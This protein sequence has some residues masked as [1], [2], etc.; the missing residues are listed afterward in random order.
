MKKTA[1]LAL[2]LSLA[3]LAA[4]GGGRDSAAGKP[5]SL[6]F[7]VGLDGDIYSLDPGLCWD[8][9]TNQVGAQ[10]AEGLVTLDEAGNL[11]PLLAKSWSQSDDLTY[12]YE[13]RDDVTFSD[14]SRMTMEDVLFTFNRSRDPEGGSFFSDFFADVESIEATGPWQ[15]TVRLGKPSAVFKFVPATAAGWI[16]SKDYYE[17]HP[18]DFGTE[19]GGMVGTGPFAYESWT[20]GQEIVL[21]KNTGYWNREKL[22]ANI[23]DRLVFKIIEDDTTRVLAMKNGEIDYCQVLPADM[24]GEIES[25]PDLALSHCDSYFLD[26]LALNTQKPPFDDRNARLAVAHAL[27]IPELFTAVIKDA[28]TPGSVLPFGPALYGADAGKWQEYIRAAEPSYNPDRARQY[29]SRSAYPNGF[30]FTLMV[31]TNSLYQQMGLY[32][33]E[34]LKQLNINAEIQRLPLEEISMHQ[35]GEYWDNDGRRIYDGLI[36]IWGADYPDLNGN[37]EF[38]YASSQAGENGVNAAVFDNPEVDG[39]ITEQRTTLDSEKRFDVQKRLVDIIAGEAPYII[40]NYELGHAALNKKYTNIRATSAGL[41]WALPL[42]N[43][44]KAD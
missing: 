25:S 13:V 5:D 21:R 24:I 16:F 22:A 39:L 40:L 33:Q 23:I 42:Q 27:N 34:A 19:A 26:F 38:M 28:G 1:Y 9:T 11:A 18:G 3:V 17:Q 8:W 43:V 29:L 30:T 12:V 44:R 35:M 4:C 32:I 37:L 7:T 6:V 20:D 2:G 15:L 41:L 31:S 10:I 36:A 14:G